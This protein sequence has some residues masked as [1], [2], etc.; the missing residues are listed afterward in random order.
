[1]RNV[2]ARFEM[3]KALGPWAVIATP[4]RVGTVCEIYDTL[5][6]NAC[7]RL[8]CGKDAQI[9]PIVLLG[10]GPD[11]NNEW[12]GW[13]DAMFK[14]M[15]DSIH[16]AKKKYTIADT[17]YYVDFKDTARAVDS[18]MALIDGKGAKP[19]FKMDSAQP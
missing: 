19:P 13:V 18:I 9:T 8:R 7:H 1:Q 6:E 17:M 11:Q 16:G 10:Y 4:G 12:W 15:D 3:V 14:E 5:M 2:T